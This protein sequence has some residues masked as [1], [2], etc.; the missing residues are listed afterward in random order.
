MTL[1][2]R[3]NVTRREQ[4]GRLALGEETESYP[5]LLDD[6]R[7]CCA[8]V[9]A[10]SEDCDL[11]F[12]G[13]SPESLFDY[14]SGAFFDTSWRDRLSLLNVSMMDVDRPELRIGAGPNVRVIRE[15]FA[16]LHLTPREIATRERGIAFVDLVASGAGSRTST[17]SRPSGPPR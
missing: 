4:L 3:W 15:H 1:P 10:T 11:V 6:L 8:R 2:F 13:R 7:T 17:G 9:V 14:M 16:A 12:V 5:A